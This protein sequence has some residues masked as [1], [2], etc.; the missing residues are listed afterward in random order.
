MR[1][2]NAFEH[3]LMTCGQNPGS[4]SALRPPGLTALSGCPGCAFCL[5]SRPKP[6]SL[7]LGPCHA[8]ASAAVHQPRTAKPQEP[9]AQRHHAPALLACA[10]PR[11]RPCRA[12]PMGTQ[13]SGPGP[14]C[15]GHATQ[16]EP[17]RRH[18]LSTHV[19]CP[20]AA[21]STAGRPDQQPRSRHSDAADGAGPHARGSQAPGSGQ[22]AL[23]RKR[24]ACDSVPAGGRRARHADPYPARLPSCT[25][26]CRPG[27]RRA[28]ATTP[29]R[30]RARCF[31]RA[32]PRS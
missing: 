4:R 27:C 17:A 21:H 8:C 18:P 23:E 16:R 11:V 20:A 3:W 22:P 28:R 10:G 15:T 29:C 14:G 31:A 5:A 13:Q 1:G 25:M 7:C 24:A 32:K 12:A 9:Q 30:A 6:Y 2:D 26:P 19:A